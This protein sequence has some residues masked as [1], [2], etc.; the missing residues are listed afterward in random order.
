M[1]QDPSAVYLQWSKAIGDKTVKSIRRDVS[2]GLE[3]AGCYNQPQREA[4]RQINNTLVLLT[5]LSNVQGHKVSF[6]SP[7]SFDKRTCT[8]PLIIVQ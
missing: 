8:I 1:K 5:F 7:S 2:V 4:S 6:E 3:L